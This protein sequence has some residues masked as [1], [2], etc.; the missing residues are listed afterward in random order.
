MCVYMY[1][2]IYIYTHVYTHTH[3]YILW[4][5][6]GRQ[7]HVAE[8]AAQQEAE[9]APRGVEAQPGLRYSIVYYTILYYTI[10]YYTIL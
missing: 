9:P 10:L 7:V 2:Y 3:T 1:V 5:A 4:R 6:R 8:G